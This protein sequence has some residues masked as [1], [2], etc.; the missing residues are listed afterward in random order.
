MD[1]YMNFAVGKLRIHIDRV[2]NV[3]GNCE[4]LTE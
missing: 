1:T 3:I 2:A 4:A